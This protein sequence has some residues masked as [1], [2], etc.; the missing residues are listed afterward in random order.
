MSRRILLAVR[1]EAAK[2]TIVIFFSQHE[3]SQTVLLQHG[4]LIHKASH[5]ILRRAHR[6]MSQSFILHLVCNEVIFGDLF[7]CFAQI[8]P[9][10]SSKL[11]DKL[12]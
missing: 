3:T 12:R 2:R 7:F 6:N 8:N 5:K 1:A 10:I 4:G 9:I 11:Y